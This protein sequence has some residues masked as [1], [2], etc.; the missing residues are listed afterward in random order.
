[1]FNSWLH[2]NRLA[3]EFN[4]LLNGAVCGTPF[5]FQKNDLHIPLEKAGKWRG[6]HLSLQ[7]PLP[8]LTIETELP[9]P[10]HKVAVLGVLSGKVITSVVCRRNDRQILFDLDNG[11]DRLLF[12]LYG[13]NGNVFYIDEA[14]RVTASFKKI[15]KPIEFETSGFGTGAQIFP[16][17][18]KIV[19]L[20]YSHPDQSLAYFLAKI[21][22]PVLPKT[23]IAEVCWRSGLNAKELLIN[24]NPSQIHSLLKILDEL[25]KALINPSP[26]VFQSEPPVFSL[27]ELQF[28]KAPA[29]HYPTLID[30]QN[31]FVHDFLN[32]HRLAER[33]RQLLRQIALLL[34]AAQR[35]LINQRNDL[36]ALPTMANYREWADT[37]MALAGQV[38]PH[39]KIATLPSLNDPDCE[40]SIPLDPKLS[41]IEN[42]QRYYAKSR[43]IEDSRLELTQK[44]AE[45]EN[46]IRNY[47]TARQQITDATDSKILRAISV[48]L[49]QSAQSQSTVETAHQPYTRLVLDGWEIL[50]GKSARDND[51]LTTKVA[52]PHDFWFHAQGTSGSHIVVRNPE[53]APSLPRHIQEKVA[54]FAAFYSKSK[55]STVVPVAFT[56]CKYVSKPRHS[57]P[58]A[59][60]VRFEKSLIVEPL[61]PRKFI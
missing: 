1:V 18:Q 3:S 56:Q 5:T 27:I 37:L 61:D 19:D 20:L 55:H 16:D 39:L 50:I 28:L 45:T 42:A 46:L 49:P 54:G 11:T 15:K 35:K 32:A 21:L 57:A 34:A 41:A 12:R 10:R 9:Q 33:R 40:I 7:A 59:V 4:S 51:E 53:K 30:A 36:A 48:R 44:I 52:R 13:I 38:A 17:Q 2:I 31:Q 26:C 8:F 22:Q 58:G 24:F 25:S 23:I 29:I 47:E 14:G 6:I 43:Q 60:A